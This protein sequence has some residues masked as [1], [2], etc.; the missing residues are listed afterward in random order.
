MLVVSRVVED[1]PSPASRMLLVA[2]MFSSPGLHKRTT[3][4]G[5][6]ND[7]CMPRQMVKAAAGSDRKEG[8][9]I[10]NGGSAAAADGSAGLEEASSGKMVDDEEKEEDDMDED[11]P[12]MPVRGPLP[13]QDGTW[14]SCIR[15]LDPVE[16]VTVECLELGEYPSLLA[17]PSAFSRHHHVPMYSTQ[18]LVA[19][20]L[21]PRLY[22]QTALDKRS[23]MGLSPST[24]TN[25]ITR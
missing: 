15:L 24:L 14:A 3:E 18:I 21:E 10:E 1:S 16:G 4:R 25:L 9:A 2:V 5:G 23:G 11:T 22:R 20:L 12:V 13:P 6:G 19:L 8:L 17:S 7:V